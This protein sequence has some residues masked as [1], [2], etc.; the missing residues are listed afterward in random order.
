MK[1]AKIASASGMNFFICSR[2]RREAVE[3]A[4]ITDASF[5]FGGFA[6]ENSET[7]PARQ[8]CAREFHA[9]CVRFTHGNFGTNQKGQGIEIKSRWHGLC[10]RSFP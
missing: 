2:Y 6:G 8:I 9:R 10:Q 7:I 5:C 3:F 4:G 1:M